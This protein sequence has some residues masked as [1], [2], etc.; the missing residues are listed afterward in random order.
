MSQPAPEAVTP[1]VSNRPSSNALSASSTTLSRLQDLDNHY[2]EL[3]NEWS[4][5]LPFNLDKGATGHF[6][7]YN[8]CSIIG[9][10]QQELQW[11]AAK[12]FPEV[13]RPH[14][15]YFDTT[16]YPP[17][18]LDSKSRLPDNCQSWK[19]LKKD[20]EAA[21]HTSGCPI[22]CNGGTG[23][24]PNGLPPPNRVF[25]CGCKY[26]RYKRDSRTTSKGQIRKDS[27]VN[28]DKKGRRPKGQQ[29]IRRSSTK[30]AVGSQQLCGF[31]IMISWDKFGY[32]VNQRAGKGTHKGHPKGVSEDLALPGRLVTPEEREFVRDL[33]ECCGGAAIGRNYMFKKHGKFLPTASINNLQNTH[34]LEKNVEDNDPRK[35]PANDVEG[36]LRYFDT[37]KDLSYQVL[38]DVPVEKEDSHGEDSDSGSAEDED[39]EDWDHRLVSTK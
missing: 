36:L 9:K 21:A 15:L 8:L 25:L 20:L 29:L 6:Q 23:K 31:R 28:S 22:I 18:T 17:P 5:E 27:F 34:L 19:D 30:L 39:D 38:W 3:T 7:S 26:R 33:A 37:Q 16:A 14:R 11:P 32:F 2:R 35:L 13:H 1:R 10:S 12:A 24:L 4:V